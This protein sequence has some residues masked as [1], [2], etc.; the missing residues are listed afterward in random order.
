MDEEIEAQNGSVTGLWPYHQ[1]MTE[2]V[3]KPGGYTAS[4]LG[5]IV[6]VAGE[7]AS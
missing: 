4:H 2:K 3:F 5:D 7:E 6:A 1:L